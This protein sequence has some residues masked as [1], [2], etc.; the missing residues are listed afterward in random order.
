MKKETKLLTKK[1]TALVLSLALVLGLIPGLTGVI[2]ADLSATIEV[3]DCVDTYYYGFND[4]VVVAKGTTFKFDYDGLTDY[5]TTSADMKSDTESVEYDLDSLGTDFKARILYDD[6]TKK[7]SVEVV[8]DYD[9]VIGSQDLYT[10][11]TA[12]VDNM[13]VISLGETKTVADGAGVY[14]ERFYKV[15]RNSITGKAKAFTIVPSSDEEY[16]DDYEDEDEDEEDYDDY[17][18]TVLNLYHIVDGQ[19]TLIDSNDDAE[20]EVAEDVDS[21]LNFELPDEGDLVVGVVGF[22]LCEL[23][24]VQLKLTEIAHTITNVKSDNAQ[25]LGVFYKGYN[26][27]LIVA[28]GTTIDFTLDNGE[29][30]T[31]EC[32]YYDDWYDEEDN[33]V[34]VVAGPIEGKLFK[35]SD[36]KVYLEYGIVG[37]EDIKYMELYTPVIKEISEIPDMPSGEATQL[38]TASDEKV[39]NYYKITTGNAPETWTFKTEGAAELE[40]GMTLYISDDKGNHI[41]T[42][43]MGYDDEAEIYQDI[44][45]TLE[46][47][48]NSTYIIAAVNDSDAAK[49]FDISIASEKGEEVTTT[50]EPTTVAPTTV[51]PTTAPVVTKA[52]VS[53]PAKAVIK[54]VY[55]KKKSAKKLK[56]KLKKTNGAK[57]YQVAVFKS[58]KTAKKHKKAIYKKYVKKIKVTL[59]S[60]KLKGKKKLFVAARAYALNGKAKVF[61]A[62]SKTKKV[63]VK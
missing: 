38:D 42:I 4:D 43:E 29:T 58:K 15:D 22:D 54:K 61:G 40:D 34:L 33:S 57:G 18:D 28:T 11:K 16:V 51:A 55:K 50:A 49:A 10:V 35:P 47:P 63:K 24:N 39:P 2:K 30:Y 26:D 23:R 59:K 14:C 31:W 1:L 36:G 12:S 60:K 45:A 5:L 41:Q 56:L 62:W 19:A 13:P 8:N 20:E 37:S 44:D 27:N 6:S 48:A 9:N 25:E 17:D 46:V 7:V 52:P 21:L 32:D 53:K 3:I